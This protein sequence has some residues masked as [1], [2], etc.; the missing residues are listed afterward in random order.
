MSTTAQS[1]SGLA[2]AIL[3][4]LATALPVAFLRTPP[5]IDVLGHIGRYELQTGLWREPWLQQFYSFRWQVLGNLGADLLVQAVA[6]L[7]GVLGS[8]RLA[9]AL[10]PLLAATGIV[11]L[12]R[13]VH[14]RV[15]PFAVCA[16]ALIY[17]LP[18]T[19]GFLNFSLSMALALLAFALW[20]RLGP[21]WARTILFVPV[22][23]SLWLCH[24]FGWAFLGI[25]CT[26]ESLVRARD[27]GRSWL[28]LPLYA[29]RDEWP[30][31][32]PLVP[33]LVWRS[34]ADGADIS[35]WFDLS[36]KA[37]WLIGIQRLSWEWTDKV[38]AGL[39]VAIIYV[40]F[41]S[42]RTSADRTLALAAAIALA[43]FLLLPGQIFGSVFAD[44][45][46]TPYVV[47]LGLLA[48]RDTGDA[49]SGRLL[50]AV[51]L[52]FLAFRLALTGYV[53]A[54]RQAILEHQL[55]ALDVI[56]EHARVATL[57]EV[58]CHDEWPLPWF[59]HIGSVA[60]VRKH[61]FANDQWANSS[62][63][64]LH[65][66]FP[67]GRFAV[68][69]RQLFFPSRCGMT[70]TLAQSMAELP[71]REFT[72]VWVLGVAPLDIP[73]RRDLQMIWRRDDAAVFRVA[74]PAQ[75]NRSA[76]AH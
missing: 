74:G 36:Q 62:M 23:L 51:A 65:V 58:P 60:L 24:T 7:L 1:R 76:S 28:M 48:L 10:V 70:P 42:P 25:L 12:S 72:R 26:A 68:D 39:L 5:I 19:W 59:S 75:N 45:R 30:L 41:R 47:M 67:A 53:Y 54:E 49:R 15:T 27:E 11:V 17:G 35:G 31:L 50:K 22:G 21:G 18:F 69:D 3:L 33:M 14:G 37:A 44:M 6:P 66:R 73:G 40:G 34:G 71:A 64:P 63:N 52:A 61:A 56:P 46:L 55:E 2:G 4:V 13:M 29:V 57:V 20:L 32:A 38:S 43:A 8:V 9:L 16:M